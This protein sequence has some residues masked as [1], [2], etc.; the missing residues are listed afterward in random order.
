MCAVK[1]HLPAV[2][3]KDLENNAEI[4]WVQIPQSKKKSVFVATVY[5]PNPNLASLELIEDSF[6]KVTLLTKPDDSIIVL[7]DFN[8]PG[9]PWVRWSSPDGDG[10][11]I[12]NDLVSLTNPASRFLEI[13]SSNGL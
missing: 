8:L 5:L 7:G 11:V 2:R 1:S 13:L 4:L 9:I 6:A 3:R 10:K 12:V